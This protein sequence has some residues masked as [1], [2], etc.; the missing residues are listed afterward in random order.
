[1][2]KGSSKVRGYQKHRGAVSLDVQYIAKC[3]VPEVKS[4][5]MHREVAKD[6]KREGDKT[7][8]FTGREIAEGIY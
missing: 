6:W 5:Q 4:R 8:I 3:K 2:A 7:A 1:V